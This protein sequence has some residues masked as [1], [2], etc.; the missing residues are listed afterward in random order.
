[1]VAAWLCCAKPDKMPSKAMASRILKVPPFDLAVFGATGDLAYRKLYP[2]LLHRYL[3]GQFTEPTKIIAMSRQELDS[4]AFRGNVAEALKKFV[5]GAASDDTI[6]A[7]VQM[8]EFVTLDIGSELGWDKLGAVL[9]SD[10]LRVRAFYLATSPDYFVPIAKKIAAH[11]LV[12]PAARI[13]IE[14][15]IGRDGASAAIINDA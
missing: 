7:F 10:R 3:D 9:G 2:A 14:K 8:I 12:T 15:P 5:S 11:Q 1:M 13:I 6:K 4:A